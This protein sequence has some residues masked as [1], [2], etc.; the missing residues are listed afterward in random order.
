MLFHSKNNQELGKVYEAGAIIFRQGDPADCFY[1]VLQGQVE[2]AREE[3]DMGWISLDIL[4]KDGIFGTTS[5][6]SQSPRL[7]TARSLVETRILTIDQNNFFQRVDDDPTLAMQV[8][9][10]MAKSS[11]RLMGKIIK[12]RKIQM[13]YSMDDD[14]ISDDF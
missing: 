1:C 7:L 6:F 14:Q 5:L 10:N 3:P 2:L 4:E 13:D 9:L 8:L 11:R 12:L